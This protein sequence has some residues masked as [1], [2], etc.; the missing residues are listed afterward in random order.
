M[1]QAYLPAASIWQEAP[2]R[3]YLGEM[4]RRHSVVDSLAL[5][6]M[7]DLPAMRLDKL[8]VYPQLATSAVSA[9]SA[10]KD[11]PA[12]LNLFSTLEETAQLVILGEPGAGKTTLSNWLAWRLSVGMVGKL[13]VLLEDKLPIPCVLRELQFDANTSMSDA[14]I[15][16]A[17]RLLGEACDAPLRECISAWVAARR[18]V[19]ILD[20][21]DEV[22]PQ[23]RQVL[24]RWM[25]QAAQDGVAAIA[26]SRLV[27]YEDGPVDCEMQDVAKQDSDLQDC[28]PMANN[29]FGTARQPSKASKTSVEQALAPWAARRYLMPFDDSRIS[30]FISNWYLQ[31]SSS[32]Q[33]AAQK[34]ADLL[35]A[36]NNSSTMLELA[37]TPNLLSLMAIVHRERAHLPEGKALLYKE[38]SNAY[39]NTI[40]LHRKISVDDALLPYGWE[41]RENWIAFVGFQMQSARAAVQSRDDKTMGVLASEAQVLQWLSEAMQASGVPDTER[42]AQLLLSWVARRSGLLLP[43]GEGVYAFVHLSFQEF[44]CA[45]Y[46]LRRVNSKAFIRDTLP[47]DAPVTKERLRQWASQPLWRESLVYLLELLSSTGD[48]EAVADLVEILFGE[49]TREEDFKSNEAG[50]AARILQDRHIHLAQAWKRSLALRCSR[51]AVA[52]MRAWQSTATLRAMVRAAYAAFVDAQASATDELVLP[53]LDA[54]SQ[55]NQIITMLVRGDAQYDWSALA[56]LKQLRSLVLASTQLQDISVL[57]G[58]SN[59]RWL[60]L[61]GTQVQDISAL[62]GLSNLRTLLLN[63]TQVQDISAL[64]GLSNLSSL[65]LNDTQVQD[66]SALAGLS[67]LFSLDI[68]NTQVRDISVLAGLT[69]LKFLYIDENINLDS[70]ALKAALPN[71]TIF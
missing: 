64:A 50:L 59:L 36:I 23:R 21:V 35:N 66:I 5:P 25:Q 18:Y 9:T 29:L 33:E 3:A 8:F 22:S 68:R 39:I 27:G 28:A 31:R 41:A 56:R 20:G 63:D 49:M 69:K 24:A 38:I 32:E 43:R 46:M 57:A 7:R 55:P 54:I 47:E 4:S 58:L 16:V 10:P 2:L 62:A 12:G 14:A 51:W 30:S 17:E 70:T 6:S 40:D 19:L 71:L 45:C 1:N 61:S 67:D 13:P 48:S 65:S 52:S 11:W 44:F 15:L 53:N 26:T 42:N 60:D 34:A 37:R